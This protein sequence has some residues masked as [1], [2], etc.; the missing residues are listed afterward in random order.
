MTALVQSARMTRRHLLTLVREPWLVSVSLVQPIIWLLLFGALFHR[1]VEI[2]GFGG[3]DYLTFLTPGIVMLNAVFGGGWSG[4]SIVQDIEQGV[5][6]RFLVTPVRR[7]ALM[8]GLLGYQAITI[9][10]Q[11]LIIVAIGLAGGARFAHPGFGLPVLVLASVLL[12]VGFASLSNTIALL[13]R[14]QESVIATVQFLALPLTF[15]SSAMMRQDLAASW[16]RDV[17]RFNPVNWAVSAGRDAL[18]TTVDL[19]TLLS[20]L[21]WLAAFAVVCGWLSVRAFASYQR[22]A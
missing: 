3:G 16:V 5:L 2:P 9:A 17:A 18:S 22:S 14:R 19:G 1:V 10:V 21:G 8:S 20:H 11:A 15:L 6:D 7:G 12:A 4:M 13:L